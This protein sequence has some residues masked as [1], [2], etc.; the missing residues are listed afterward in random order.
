MFEELNFGI[1]V[2]GFMIGYILGEQLEE[3]KGEKAAAG[4]I[5]AI[6]GPIITSTPEILSA[7]GIGLG[8]GFLFSG[9]Y[10]RK[11]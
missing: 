7:I 10:E 6:A 8:A 4:L 11:K 1:V 3:R 9:I 5:V 2:F